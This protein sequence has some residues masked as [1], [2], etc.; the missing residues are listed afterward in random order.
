MILWKE[1]ENM[2]AIKGDNIDFT[3]SNETKQ[4]MNALFEKAVADSNGYR[5]L[6]AYETIDKPLY[7]GVTTIHRYT[8]HSYVL[9][10]REVFEEFFERFKHKNN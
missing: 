8:Y 6:Y 2:G 1:E 9:G 5:L 7:L 3:K 10:Y 4:K